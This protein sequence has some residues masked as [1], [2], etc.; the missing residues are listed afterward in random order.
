VYI[1][2][3]CQIGAGSTLRDAV[4]LR[5]SCVPEGARIVDQVY[6]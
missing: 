1:E 3:D 2:R 5:D 6:A 4:I